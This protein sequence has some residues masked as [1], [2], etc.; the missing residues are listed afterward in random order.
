[1]TQIPFKIAL[2]YLRFVL[3]AA[4]KR[5]FRQA[6]AELGVWESTISRGIR[7]LEDEIGVSLFIRSPTGVKLTH[8]GGTFLSHA[9]A[10]IRHIEYGLKDASAAGRGE[11]GWIKIGIFSS[12][13]S[14]FLSDLLQAYQ[15]ENPEIGL[16][17]VEGGPVEH[18][19]AIQHHQMDIAFLAEEIVAHGC[20]TAHLWE[21][22]V[23]LALPLNHTLAGKEEV[24]WDDLHDEH[25]IVSEMHPGPEFHDCLITHLALPGHHPSVGRYGVGRD[26]L[27]K[28]VALG[29]GLTLTTEA[30]TGTTFPGICYKPIEGEKLRFRAIWASH[31]DNPAFRRLLSMARTLSRRSSLRLWE[32]KR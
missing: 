10:A 13:S 21:E 3:L 9:R 29:R 16:D 11:V 4:E 30:T 19:A 2:Q 23:C 17:F 6:A 27:M 22:K 20:E 24:G 31:N 5:S 8:A 1:V 25:F 28:L 32:R 15:T 26:N 12:L 7:D 18:V 14:G